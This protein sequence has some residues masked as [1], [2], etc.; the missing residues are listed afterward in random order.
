MMAALGHD[1]VL[2]HN[3]RLENAMKD[4][5]QFTQST[6]GSHH[7]RLVSDCARRW[8]KQL[9]RKDRI[10]A[11]M[12][13][14]PVLNAP[15]TRETF[16]MPK[17]SPETAAH[18]S[19]TSIKAEPADEEGFLDLSSQDLL[20]ASRI[21]SEVGVDPSLLYQLPQPTVGATSTSVHRASDLA[22]SF[23]PHPCSAT[24]NT[25]GS[26]SGSPSL[27]LPLPLPITPVPLSASSNF[28]SW[29][30]GAAGTLFSQALPLP[31]QV[32]PSAPSGPPTDFATLYDPDSREQKAEI[33]EIPE[34]ST[35]STVQEH[36]YGVSRKGK[37]VDHGSQVCPL[38]V[39]VL[40]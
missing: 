9:E 13:T 34:K 2:R 28:S 29:T 27:T 24:H 3:T 21:L 31:S 35:V 26:D 18:Q 37:A 11:D 16:G 8:N 36:G 10:D 33:M 5:P 32:S 14:L 23:T 7:V 40:A 1:F 39:P 20:D 25:A 4:P 38:F 6:F 17:M 22:P 30:S 12:E 15:C 19:F